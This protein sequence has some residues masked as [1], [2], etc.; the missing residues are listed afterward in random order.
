MV[1]NQLAEV[2]IAGHEDD[3]TSLHLEMPRQ[4]AQ[5][6]VGLIPHQ[7]QLGNVERFDQTVDVGHLHR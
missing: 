6:I 7:T 3:I 5:D 4:R 2:L 1:C